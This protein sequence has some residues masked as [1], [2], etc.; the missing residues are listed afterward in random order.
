MASLLVRMQPW[1]TSDPTDAGSLVPWMPKGRVDLPELGD[2]F[3]YFLWALRDSNPRGAPI[4]LLIGVPP[5]ALCETLGGQ[6]KAV[7]AVRHPSH[8][9]AA[10]AVQ[11]GVHLLGVDHDYPVAASNT[12]STSGSRRSMFDR[13]P[14]NLRHDL[15]VLHRSVAMLRPDERGLT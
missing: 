10:L 12:A 14:V 7:R 8:P 2:Y 3:S 11:V 13:R 1:L 9:A 6:V 4:R 5:L 15:L